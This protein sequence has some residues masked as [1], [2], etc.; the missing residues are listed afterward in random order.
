MRIS[1]VGL[2][3]GFSA[4][5]TTAVS[6][7]GCSDDAEPAAAAT[8]KAAAPTKPSADP[9]T[10]TEEHNYAVRKIYFGDTDRSGAASRDAWRTFG[11]D[12]D[13]KNTNDKATAS[14]K[15]AAETV[16]DGDDGIDNAFGSKLLPLALTVQS[17]LAART[18]ALLE[19]G[20][21]TTMLVVKGIDDKS[22]PQT[23]IGLSAQLFAAGKFSETGAPTWSTAD[24]WPVRPELLNGGTLAGGAK[25]RFSDAWIQSGQF[26]SGAPST[27][28]VGLQMFGNAVELSI[29]RAVVVF[30]HLAPGKVVNGTV[31]GVVNTEELIAQVGPL[32]GRATTTLCPGT[33]LLTN[34]LQTLRNASDMRID[35]SSDPSLD[36]DGISIALGFEA[37]EIGLPKTVAPPAGAPSPDPCVADAGTD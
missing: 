10:S 6:A 7:V 34:I 17:D 36:C 11:F 21:A 23:N 12:L 24:D 30:D 3:V 16:T 9:T 4:L 1:W 20:N 5:A 31:A 26:A 14:C 27:I 2:L 29:H 15:S 35:G 25:V 37:T 28:T 18:N 22:I 8:S 32:A 19:A 33:D 13:G